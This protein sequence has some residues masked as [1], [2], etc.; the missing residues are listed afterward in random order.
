[1]S[2]K[3][4][5]KNNSLQRIVGIATKGIVELNGATEVNIS[6][7]EYVAV[8]LNPG[9]FKY[10]NIVQYEK[11]SRVIKGTNNTLP[12]S[13]QVLCVGG[14][15]GGA[16]FAGGGGGGGGV[17]FD[18]SFIVGAAITNINVVVG[19]GGSGGGFPNGPAGA[20]MA[21]GWVGLNTSIGGRGGNSLFGTSL[22]ALGGGGGW[23]APPASPQPT[24]NV[25]NRTGG[26]TGGT[27]HPAAPITASQP[28]TPQGS[29]TAINYGNAGGVTPITGYSMPG[30]GGG[31]TA[32]GQNAVIPGNAGN[33]GAGFTTSISGTSYPYGAGGGGGTGGR[34]TGPGGSWNGGW[35]VGG[36]PT[37]GR[38]GGSPPAGPPGA[39]DIG[40]AGSDGYGG[41]GGGG[42]SFIHVGPPGPG[43]NGGSGTVIVRYTKG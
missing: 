9:T 1:M 15:G 23:L 5:K 8:Y 7:N 42:N 3:F 31:A 2:F 37:A 22:T 14:G 13:V 33:G 35:G 16:G 32:V 12:T 10:S 24:F 39:Q 4:F 18:N 6:G 43:R 30:G 41:G 29:P 26:S 25:D 19:Y 20:P 36:S 11:N 40:T 17:V 21:P 38:G 28:T 27:N 34:W